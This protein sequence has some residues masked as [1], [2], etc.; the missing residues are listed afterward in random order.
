MFPA[1]QHR[2]V[3][4]FLK[5]EQSIGDSN[6]VKKVTVIA[7]EGCSVRVPCCSNVVFS[8]F[9]HSPRL[10]FLSCAA[11]GQV[12]LGELIAPPEDEGLGTDAESVVC[13][14]RDSIQHQEEVMGQLGWSHKLMQA[15]EEF[16]VCSMMLELKNCVS[17]TEKQL[18]SLVRAPA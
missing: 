10:F 2:I 14:S 9:V 5:L 6:P 11:G 15:T 12:S 18:T 17:E 8:F 1:L 7:S 13:A 16:Q 3:G 4:E